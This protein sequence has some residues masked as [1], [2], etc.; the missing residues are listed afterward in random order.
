M[1]RYNPV[2]FLEAPGWKLALWEIHAV[3]LSD[4]CLLTCS[5]LQQ[6]TMTSCDVGLCSA[7]NSTEFSLPDVSFTKAGIHSSLSPGNSKWLTMET[8]AMATGDR[9]M[10]EVPVRTRHKKH[11]HL[12]ARATPPRLPTNP[13]SAVPKTKE[14]T[15]LCP[16]HTCIL[17]AD[18][19]LPYNGHHVRHRVETSPQSNIYCLWRATG[20][21]LLKYR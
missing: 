20:W 14:L 1:L 12:P 3:W 11:P 8:E 17:G 2:V 10:R 19:W 4:Q 15:Q 7:A 13:W 9:K 16:L 5:H 6:W 21:T 18:F